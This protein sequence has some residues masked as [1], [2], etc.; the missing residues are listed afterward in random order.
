M[1]TFPD[2][3]PLEAEIQEQLYP[4]PPPPPA[5]E[6]LV[7]RPDGKTELVIHGVADPVAAIAFMH[8]EIA[9]A[10]AKHGI[11]LKA[12]PGRELEEMRK[13]FGQGSGL[14]LVTVDFQTARTEAFKLD[15]RAQRKIYKALKPK[16]KRKV[17]KKVPARKKPTKR[18]TRR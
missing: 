14:Y 6:T 8:P 1:S 5:M 12:R 3:T 7:E 11:D 10:A 9:E 13:Y 15:E 16:R 2:E 4:F 17:V 18:K